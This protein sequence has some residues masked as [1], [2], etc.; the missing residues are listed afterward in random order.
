MNSATSQSFPSFMTRFLIAIRPISL[1]ATFTPW[2]I[3][4][5]FLS[6]NKMPIQWDYSFIS[7]VLAIFLQISVNLLNDVAD[8]SKKIDRPDTLG[9][10]GVLVKGW[11]ELNQLNVIAW[12]LALVALLFGFFIIPKDDHLIIL[13]AI[14][15]GLALGYSFKGGGLKYI[16]FG[17]FA[18]FITCGPALT[19]AFSLVATQQSYLSS[20]IP[21]IFTGLL[22]V[23]I[24]H[25]NNFNDFE[26]DRAA[27]ATTFAHVLGFNLSKIYTLLLYAFAYFSAYWMYRN[28][29]IGLFALTI[30]M[31]ALVLILPM[32]RRIF[33]AQNSSDPLILH[34]RFDAAKLHLLMTLLFALG[35][36]LDIKMA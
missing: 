24:L 5:A 17:D 20:L 29:Q 18:V 28:Q 26:T 35:V 1:T 16:G 9:G 23:A 10:S 11:F 25:A 3:T 14:S 36:Y 12:S 22:S 32:L 33:K 21:G 7:A 31:L 19:F 34:I 27:G 30:P 15:I 4:V 8:F 13:L 2:L 6:Y